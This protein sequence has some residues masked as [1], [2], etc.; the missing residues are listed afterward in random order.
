MSQP[1]GQSKAQ[2]RRLLK[3]RRAQVTPEQNQAWS[4][5]AQTH[6][7]STPLWEQARSVALYHPFPSE[8]ST[9]LL[10]SAAWTSG[11]RVALPIT[12]PMGQALRFVLVHP[13]T[14]RVPGPMGTQEPPASCIDIPSADLD[15]VILP[16]LGWDGTG[17]RMGYGGG[18]YDRSFA[19]SVA[20]RIQL[21]FALQEQP[22]LPRET[23]DLPM[24]GVVTELGL[25]LF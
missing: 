15:L 24:D 14:P 18:Y 13:K 22:G 10:L 7:L 4:Q 3:A 20:Q 6:L 17:T 12:P 25:R 23:H 19:N 9:A 1:S 21:A 11:K 2:L 16:G 8:V 5:S